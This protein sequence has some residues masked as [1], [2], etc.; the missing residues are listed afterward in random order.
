M[1]WIFSVVGECNEIGT[2]SK[3]DLG[4]CQCNKNFEGTACENCILGLA[5]MNCDQCDSGYIL[6]EG[7]CSG[8][9]MLKD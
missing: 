1:L 4:T 6:I 8:K 7:V 3:T 2:Q 9:N 5:G